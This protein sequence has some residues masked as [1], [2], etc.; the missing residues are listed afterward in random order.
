MLQKKLLYPHITKSIVSSRSVHI[1]Q[2]VFGERLGGAQPDKG[3]VDRII[4][5]VLDVD[6]GL[7]DL[8]VYELDASR[9]CNPRRCGA[10]RG[11]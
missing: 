2:G 6:K 8:G 1:V 10:M 11:E 9:R 7:G 4:L 3:D 5:L